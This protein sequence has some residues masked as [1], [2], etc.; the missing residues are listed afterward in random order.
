MQQRGIR[1][2][3][4]DRV[5]LSTNGKK[6]LSHLTEYYRGVLVV[7]KIGGIFDS[8]IV[9][10]TDGSTGHVSAR[11]LYFDLTLNTNKIGGVIKDSPDSKAVLTKEKT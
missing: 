11:P 7:E 10:R 1:L 9:R 2:K 3:E 4:G 6:M 5:V 8:L